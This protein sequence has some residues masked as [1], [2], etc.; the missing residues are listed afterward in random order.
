LHLHVDDCFNVFIRLLVW[1]TNVLF[2]LFNFI[3]LHMILVT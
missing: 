3:F 1:E 2:C